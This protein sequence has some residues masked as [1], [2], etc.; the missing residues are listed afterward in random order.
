MTSFHKNTQGFSLVLFTATFFIFFGLVS[1]IADE[2]KQN[3]PLKKS[4]ASGLDPVL[5]S[6]AVK[7]FPANQWVMNDVKINLPE[8]W[9]EGRYCY[10]NTY[11]SI[12]FCESLNV[13]IT[14]DGYTYT[15]VGKSMTNNYSDS[16]YI[17]DP[18]KNELE[19]FKR[20]NW[21]AG[22]RSKNPD[23]TSYPLDEN[24]TDP[25]PCPRHLYRGIT[26]LE[27]TNTFYLINGANAGVPNEHPKYKENNG[28]DTKT[29]WGMDVSRK[30][31]QLLENP[32]LK[33]I[34]AYESTLI[35]IP[36]TSKLIYLDDW[37][38]ASYDAK[39]SKWTVLMGNNG[40]PVKTLKTTSAILVDSKRQK[41]IFYGGQAWTSIKGAE[42]QMAKNQL[43]SYDIEKN[44]LEVING[45][46]TVEFEKTRPCAYLSDIDKYLYLTDKGHYIFD[47]VT[48][49]WENLKV[50]MPQIPLSWC[51]MTY[52]TKRGLVI[53]NEGYKWAVLRID[54]KVLGKNIK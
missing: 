1:I 2:N 40:T 34:D 50:E 11:A 54:E 48:N 24:K 32:P 4:L 15:P 53:L 35:A 7:K 52:D 6:E 8:K 20:S 44:V 33:R 41:I 45:I 22:A 18:I 42:P 12:V 49:Q 5:S 43:H 10:I 13:A 47:P 26:W 31:W 9:K 51:Y 37:S 28:T 3:I 19:L 29:F 38:I 21:R 17:F 25:T 30:T 14:M 23:V 39:L 27:E 46:G 36:G 16:V